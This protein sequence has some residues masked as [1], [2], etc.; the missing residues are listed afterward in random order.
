MFNTS[1]EKHLGSLELLGEGTA[2]DA[3]QEAT[4]AVAARHMATAA[5]PG[6][7]SVADGA[8]GSAMFLRMAFQVGREDVCVR[9]SSSFLIFSRFIF[10]IF[11][12]KML[13]GS[14]IIIL[15]NSLL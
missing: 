3:V 4:A 7:D 9:I 14:F 10:L 2:A 13:Q 15:S 1:E 12:L 6:Q 11:A 5:V 8:V